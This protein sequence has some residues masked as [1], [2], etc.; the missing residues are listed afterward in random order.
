MKQKHIILTARF[1]SAL[2][3][4]YYM[5]IVGFVALFTFTYLSLLPFSYKLIILFMVYCF[6]IVLPRLCIFTYR[7]I[8]GWTAHQ[9]RLREHRAVPYI[10]SIFSYVA[11]LYLMYRMHLPRYMCGIIV[12]ALLIQIVCAVVN[13][14]WKISTH[15]AGAGGVIGA[16]LGY[17]ILFMFNPIWW[18]CITI[19][20]SGAVNSS[21]M[22]LRQHSLGQVSAGTL[23]GIACGFAG[24]VLL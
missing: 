8:N 17:S 14:W 20:I 16:L 22:L 19:L 9:L 5:P 6:T 1:F 13:I 12:S 2:F 11:C 15:S 10:L 23:V 7:K 3:R 4:P 21:R 18:L 24:I